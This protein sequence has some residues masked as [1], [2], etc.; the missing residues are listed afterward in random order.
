M[1]SSQVQSIDKVTGIPSVAQRQ[2]L[3]I[4][5]TVGISQ[6]QT[7]DTFDVSEIQMAS[8]VLWL[9]VAAHAPD[10]DHEIVRAPLMQSMETASRSSNSQ[11]FQ[12]EDGS[13]MC[14]AGSAGKDAH[15]LTCHSI[16]GR[17]RGHASW[18]AWARTTVMPVTRR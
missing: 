10:V 15:R 3:P 8:T 18:P 5:E 12:V 2:V 1:E 7:V 16:I 17:P 13:G 14:K 4:Q 9:V 11:R 6:L